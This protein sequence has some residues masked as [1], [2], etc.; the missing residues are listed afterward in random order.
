MVPVHLTK[1]IVGEQNLGQVA[2]TMVT[3]LITT[4]KREGNT[5]KGGVLGPGVFMPRLFQMLCA[6]VGSTYSVFKSFSY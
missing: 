5:L 3:H 2:G 1:V 6:V 4:T